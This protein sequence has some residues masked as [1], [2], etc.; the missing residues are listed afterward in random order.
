[1]SRL[2]V[3]TPPYSNRL[4]NTSWFS[5]CVLLESN[6]YIV[7]EDRVT[8]LFGNYHSFKEYGSLPENS[9]HIPGQ[10]KIEFDEE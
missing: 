1:M 6:S 7:S 4:W 3:V 8:S 5:E 9:T 10:L 2:L